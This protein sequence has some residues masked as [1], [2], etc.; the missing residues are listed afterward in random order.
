[1]TSHPYH[2]LTTWHALLATPSA[3]RLANAVRKHKSRRKFASIDLAFAD[4][5][6]LTLSGELHARRIEPLKKHHLR[7]K[8]ALATQNVEIT[9]LR[10]QN[11]ALLSQITS[12]R[13]QL[14]QHH[15]PSPLTGFKALP[16]RT[17]KR[18]KVLSIVGDGRCLLYS[19]LQSQC[20]MLPSAAE[21]DTLRQRLREHLLSSY[22]AAEWSTRVPDRASEP[23]SPQ[24]FADRFLSRP[25]THLPPDTVCIWQD[26]H[27]FRTDVFILQSSSY[28]GQ[29]VELVP[30][31]GTATHALI[32]RLT[33]GGYSGT[34]H[35]ESIT[36]DGVTTLP[37]RHDVIGELDALHLEYLGSLCT[38]VK[39]AA[40]KGRRGKKK[41]SELIEVE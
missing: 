41:Q 15:T 39:R 10:H 9:A 33:Y 3:V 14:A 4:H 5:R 37:R 35:W 38:E 7:F 8:D 40:Q 18:L 34:G 20:A 12:V 32:L 19:L 27:D 24:D 21:A 11:T 13:G 29:K 23:L 16:A 2:H 25:T 28:E 6:R 26:L 1:M 36:C 30:C 22:T 17:T 31:R